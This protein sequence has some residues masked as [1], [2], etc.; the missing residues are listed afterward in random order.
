MR[1][2]PLLLPLVTVLLA[3]C[4]CAVFG[5]NLPPGITG[6][7]FVDEPVGAVPLTGVLVE[8]QRQIDE[9]E[10]E[11]TERQVDVLEGLIE[12]SQQLR[13]DVRDKQQKME[14]IFAR[15]DRPTVSDVGRAR[16]LG[17]KAL[18]VDAMLYA[19]WMHYRTYLPYGSEP[20]AYAPARAA[21]LLSPETRALGGLL[22]L[23]AELLR[24]DN[25]Q[26]IVDVLSPHPPI[27]HALNVGDPLVGYP[28]EGY[29]R[30]VGALT[31][32]DRR[33]L[34]AS[35]LAAVDRARERLDAMAAGNFRVARL[36]Q[37]IDDS[38][39]AR[40]VRTEGELGRRARYAWTV[41]SRSGWA[42]VGPL[43]PGPAADPAPTEVRAP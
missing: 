9:A 30:M 32:P 36:L 23:A 6:G 41:V 28:A 8:R 37:M 14:A 39:T 38:R 19:L 18:E 7:T 25:V 24:L 15:G 11:R 22:A 31:D 12:A 4:G 13:T 2:P 5:T 16:A 3:P 21:S 34:L 17:K 10:R 27:I 33:A 20:D 26:E 29:D 1:A 35:Q 40:D 42:L 43:L